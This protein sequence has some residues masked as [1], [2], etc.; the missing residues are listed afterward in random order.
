MDA[1]NV[2]AIPGSLR[3]SSYDAAVLQAA[4]MVAPHGMRVRLFE[5]LAALPAFR[6][7]D[8]ARPPLLVQQWRRELDSADALLI[9]SPEFANGASSPL[10]NALDWAASVERLGG[11]PVGIVNTSLH[12]LMANRALKKALLAMS[13]KPVEAASFSI[14][15]Q[16]SGLNATAILQRQE[17][18]AALQ[19]A[20]LALRRAAM[21]R[22]RGRAGNAGAGGT[23]LPIESLPPWRQGPP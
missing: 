20:V 21:A 16:G 5:G 6:A 3:T 13:A 10:Q 18:V 7:G 12:T 11:I 17:M 2:L 23:E 22:H 1:L 8:D 14:P 19:H 9:A 4:A 15:L